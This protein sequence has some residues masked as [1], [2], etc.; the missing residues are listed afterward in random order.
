MI[1]QIYEIQTPQEAEKCIELGVDHIGSVLLS[2]DEWRLPV[3]RDVFRLSEGT[4]TKNSLIPLFKD[5]D[6]FY[7]SIDYYRPHF[8]HFCE[9]L[10]DHEDKEIDLEGLFDLDYYLKHIDT[11]FAQVFGKESGT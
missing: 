10:L 7:R 4:E 2:R 11:I 9:S 8:I 5:L 6:D 1:V 3:L